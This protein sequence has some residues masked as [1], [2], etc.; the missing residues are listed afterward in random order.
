MSSRENG[1]YTVGWIC[2]LSTEYIAAIAFLDESYGGASMVHTHDNNDYTLGKMGN[3][4]DM[5]HSFPNIRIGLMVGIGGGAPSSKQDIRLGDIV[6]SAPRHGKGGVLQYDFGKTIQEQGFQAARF[7]DQPPTTLGAAVYGL[8]SQYKIDGHQI[9]EKI[10]NILNKKQRL[11]KEY[12]KPNADQDRLY[13][14]KIVH[15]PADRRSCAECCSD[16]PSHLVYRDS[17]TE[18]SDDPMIHYGLIASADTLMKDA[19]IRDRL[20]EQ[21]EVLCFEME[22]AGLVNHFPCLI[23]RGICDYSDSHKNK[24]WQRYAAMAAAAYAKD[25]LLRIA[26]NNVEN[27][28]RISEPILVSTTTNRYHVANETKKIV[29]TLYLEGHLNQ[30]HQLLSAAD[31]SINHNE[32]LGKRHPGSGDWFLK[33]DEYTAWTTGTGQNSL[34]WLNGISGCGKSVLAS[35]IMDDLRQDKARVNN[36]LYFYFTFTDSAKQSFEGALRSFAGQL[37]SGGPP[38]V[39]ATLDALFVSQNDGNSQPNLTTLKDTI[40]KML[41][42]AGKTWIVID[43]L[44]ECSIGYERN[45]LLSWTNDLHARHNSTYFL[46]TSRPQYDIKQAIDRCI[47]KKKVI[48][49]QNDQ[50]N[51]DIAAYIKTEVRE[52]KSLSR[53]CG[54][55]KIQEEIERALEN[56]A[57]GMLRT[58]LASLPATLD[59]TYARILAS[60]PEEDKPAATRLLQFLVYSK[61]PILLDEAVDALAIN[62]DEAPR[63]DKNNRIPVS[64]EIT[65]YCPGLLVLIS[66]LGSRYEYMYSEED[67]EMSLACLLELDSKQSIRLISTSYPLAVYAARYWASHANIAADRFDTVHKYAMELFCSRRNLK[68]TSEVNLLPNPPLE[69]ASSGGHIDMVPLLLSAG[70]NINA[71]M[72]FSTALES[73]IRARHANIVHTLLDAGADIN[74]SDGHALRFAA[75]GR[76]DL[77]RTLVE[78][79]L[80][81]NI[82]GGTSLQA[83]VSAGRLDMISMLLAA[84]ADVNAENEY[85]FTALESAAIRGNFGLVQW[86]LNAGAN[87]TV[88]GNFA[89]EGAAYIGHTETV[90]TLLAKDFNVNARGRHYTSALEAT[91]RQGY[92]LGPDVDARGT[93]GTSLQVASRQGHLD[94]VRTLLSAGA[95][96]N[97]KGGYHGTALSCASSAGHVDIVRTLLDARADV[98]VKE[99]RPHCALCVSSVNSHFEVVAALLAA[100]A[101][102]QDCITREVEKSH[103]GSVAFIRFVASEVNIA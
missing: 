2:V 69:A 68:I 32:A 83:A 71:R 3:T 86:L 62:M 13:R 77:L 75:V 87:V 96:V 95:N 98:S 58:T 79:G 76:V 93:S 4:T 7:L 45:N 67:A 102:C 20:I 39:R 94:I 55:E 6:V 78:A 81:F 30:I 18:D 10:E 22:A 47:D 54:K 42:S 26:P 35:T 21:E 90:R 85:S 48:S 17:R 16:D 1:D 89:L 38:D 50:V 70:A 36:T 44:D 11:Q 60:I 52:S 51:K 53:W 19:E 15:P 12:R 92:L 27:E 8:R 57:K 25:L 97:A 37:Y 49:L 103:Q 43:A 88:Y 72:Y 84:G 9:R 66:K 46:M 82:H 80:D 28:E 63:F 23:I 5:L 14:S 24:Q 56:K 34:L 74:I 73:V 91:S 65:E 61:R 29:N 41:D 100:G 101:D 33:S 99:K 40:Q 59:E 31:P 64:E